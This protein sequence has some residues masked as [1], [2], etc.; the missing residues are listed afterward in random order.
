MKKEDKDLGTPLPKN[1]PP[2]KRNDKTRIQQLLNRRAGRE[3]DI[4]H[5]IAFALLEVLKVLEE[6]R[7]NTKRR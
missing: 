6:I 4:Q 3:Y 2:L 7:D 5:G 1:F